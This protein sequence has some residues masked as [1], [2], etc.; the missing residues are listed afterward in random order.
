[1]TRNTLPLPLHCYDEGGVVKPPLWL[2]MLLLAACADWLIFIFAVAIRDQTTFL[3]QLFYP[4]SSYLIIRLV[5]TLP[6][7]T[8]LLLLGNRERLWKKSRTSWRHC[9][10]PLLIFGILASVTVQVWQ[11]AVYHWLFQFVNALMLLLSCLFLVCLVRSRHVKLMI[12]DWR[13][14]KR[15]EAGPLS[16]S[17]EKPG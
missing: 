4:Q 12:K 10:Y 16:S 14:P 6:F 5:I 17:S 2:Y 8:V 7:L 9:I 15:T 13:H 3:L 1:M 11:I